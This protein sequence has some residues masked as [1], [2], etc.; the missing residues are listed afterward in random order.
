MGAV[1]VRMMVATSLVPVLT[2]GGMAISD[3]LANEIFKQ[4]GPS[5]MSSFIDLADASGVEKVFGPIIVLLVMM[6]ALAGSAMQVLAL[7]VR[8]IVVPIVAGL[9]PLFA[10]GSMTGVGKNGLNHLYAYLV[11]AV[12]FKPIAAMLYVVVFWLSLIHI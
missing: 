3:S 10:A 7:A 1:V 5:D 9:A 12:V 11:S 2:V 8:F 6:L 4:F